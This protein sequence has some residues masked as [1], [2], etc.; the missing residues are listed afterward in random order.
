VLRNLSATAAW[1]TLG[2]VSLD[3]L[4]RALHGA[5]DPTE[6]EAVLR[7]AQ[8]RHP[9]DVWINYDLPRAL[10]ALARRAEAIRYNTTARALRPE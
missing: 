5:G 9:D 2:P 6:A 10:E 7:R 8:R 3:L 1:E 4:G